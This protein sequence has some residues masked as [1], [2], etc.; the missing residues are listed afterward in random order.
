MWLHQGDVTPLSSCMDRV[1]RNARYISKAG[2]RPLLNGNSNRS[3]RTL[4]AWSLRLDN[5]TQGSPL[6]QIRAPTSLLWGTLPS[7]TPS[8]LYQARSSVIQSRRIESVAP[9][10]LSKLIIMC[11]L[12]RLCVFQLGNRSPVLL[13]RPP[14]PHSVPGT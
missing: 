13:T 11:V 1:P 6:L 3:E 12:T 7:L 10:H 9:W 14:E 2:P 4:P 8:A 5:P